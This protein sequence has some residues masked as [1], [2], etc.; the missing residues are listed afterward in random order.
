M[1]AV[2]GVKKV[3]V[4]VFLFPK[5]NSCC[6]DWAAVS[7]CCDSCKLLNVRWCTMFLETSKIKEKENRNISIRVALVDHEV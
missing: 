1:K 3:S 4:P 6:F 5:K 2:C 7:C